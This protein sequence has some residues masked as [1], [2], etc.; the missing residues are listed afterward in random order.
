VGVFKLTLE[1]DGAG[2]AGWQ[3]QPAGRRTV[4]DV[5]EAALARLA[6]APVR[7]TGA[8]RTDAGVHA[9]GQVASA[10]LDT[11][12]APHELARALN[13]CLPPDV[14][15]LRAE[16]AADGFHA[17]RDARGKVYRY[18][19]WNGAVRSPLRAARSLHHPRALD[20][21]AMRAAA[22]ALVGTHDFSSFRAAG[23]A[24]RTS[25]R[26][27]ERLQLRGEPGDLVELELE[28]SGFLRHMARNVVGTLLEVGRGERR[29]D[30]IEALL[31]GRDRRAAGPTAPAHGLTLVRVLYAEASPDPTGRGADPPPCAVPRRILPQ[32][33]DVGRP[34]P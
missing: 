22:A 4:Q 24:V 16:A 19:V 5:L 13:G 17:R 27:L 32:S 1:Y 11:R 26:T 20:V 15:V 30:A 29:A 2:F 3:R 34:R 10:A 6:G 12:L 33:R 18:A 21:G 7:A 9:E 8:G 25:V 31:G 28:A 14:A 23:S